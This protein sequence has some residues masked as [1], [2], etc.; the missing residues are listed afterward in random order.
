MQAGQVHEQWSSR[1]GFIMAAVGSAV[2]LGNI[3]RFPYVAGESGGGA[4][5]LVYIGC[6]VLVGAPI[7]MAELMI[8]RRGQRSPVNSYRRVAEDHGKS[9]QWKWAGAL[10]VLCA[11]TL[12]SFYSVIGGWTFA[13][14]AE[15]VTGGLSDVGA[16]GAR[17]QFGGLLDDPLRMGIWHFL[18]MG[19]TM[20]VVARGVKGGIEKAATWLMP[21]LFVLLLV[22]VGYSAIKGDFARGMSFLFS[23]DFS[24]LSGKV[25]LEA[26]GQAF[27]TLSLGMG[28]MITYGAYLS[29]DISIPR[30]TGI[31]VT[32][33]T[34]VATLA[35]VA[36]FPIVFASGLAP[37]AGPGLV[38]QT[39]PVAFAGMPGG[40][41]V[42]SLFF[43]L[44][45]FA[46]VTSSISILEPLVSWLEEQKGF[47]R[48]KVTVVAGIAIWLVGL[49]SVLGY[50]KLSHVHPL[51]FIEG[52]AYKDILDSFDYITANIFLP[53]GGMLAALF[54]GWMMS[55]E[56]VKAELGVEDGWF[57]NGWRFLARFVAPIAVGVV[58]YTSLGG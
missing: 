56:T 4:F 42:G 57:L 46:A 58:L 3:W 19:I 39:L 11:V 9:G 23:T 14:L 30:A 33:D 18:F 55:R 29:R 6:I 40:L 49:T 25:V 52:L 32:A 41:I 43:A 26:L 34:L 10:G 16:N 12:L 37:G 8:G 15:T 44:L 38:F 21:S 5:F 51:A 24:K 47:K 1:V 27:F 7:L 22:I 36:I 31:I 20:F 28:T 48:A 50:N 13:F 2:G 54:A 17:E 35:G 45:L 53:L